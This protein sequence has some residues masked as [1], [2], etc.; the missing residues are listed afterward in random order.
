MW[1]DFGGEIAREY[2]DRIDAAWK[3]DRSQK[4]A[5]PNLCS[6]CANYKSD[7][8]QICGCADYE[9]ADANL[10][11]PPRNCDAGTVS[12]AVAKEMIGLKEIGGVK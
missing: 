2:V 11:E 12:D 7:G 3:R 5:K 10:Y 6:S 4:M 8:C 9:K 1:A